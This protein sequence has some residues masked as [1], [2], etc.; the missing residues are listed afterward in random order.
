[1]A[2]PGGHRGTCTLLRPLLHCACG[3]DSSHTTCKLRWRFGTENSGDLHPPRKKNKQ[4]NNQKIRN[5]TAKHGEFLFYYW[6][7][8]V[9]LYLHASL[10]QSNSIFYIPSTLNT[11]AVVRHGSVCWRVI[12]TYDCVRNCDTKS[13]TIATLDMLTKMTDFSSSCLWIKQVWLILIDLMLITLKFVHPPPP[14]PYPESV[15]VKSYHSVTLL[16]CMCTSLYH[17]VEIRYC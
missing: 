4:K 16:S 14:S 10:M 7:T 6:D 1:M 15:P 12:H 9:W 13:K 2:Y 3:L 8:Q 11:C 17:N 5:K